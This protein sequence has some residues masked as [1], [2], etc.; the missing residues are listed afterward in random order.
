MIDTWNSGASR[1]QRKDEGHHDGNAIGKV[2]KLGFSFSTLLRGTSMR[3][4]SFGCG[5][6]CSHRI[7]SLKD[8]SNM[9]QRLR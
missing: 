6:G 7:M 1:K 5:T 8:T 4:T 3:L 2:I 9:D